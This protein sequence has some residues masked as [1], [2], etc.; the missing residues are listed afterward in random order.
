MVE[1]IVKGMTEDF[2][3]NITPDIGRTLSKILSD[4]NVVNK[5][6]KGIIIKSKDY[7]KTI[8]FTDEKTEIGCI[9]EHM[10]NGQNLREIKD[11]ILRIA[12]STEIN[13]EKE[14]KFKNSLVITQLVYNDFPLDIESRKVYELLKTFKNSGL[15]SMLIAD[16]ELTYGFSLGS[17]K[18]IVSYVRP[19]DEVP[20]FYPK[21][22]S[23]FGFSK[24]KSDKI[25]YI[26]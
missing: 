19:L 15:K 23:K 13:D 10:G 3:A 1:E 16:G 11:A 12:K 20:D 5:S 6:D 8:L 22:S 18:F 21:V 17:N 24:P 26:G 14:T 7:K 2:Y 4:W 25:F 9:S